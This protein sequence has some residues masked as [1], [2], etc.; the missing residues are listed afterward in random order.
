M[1]VYRNTP[2]NCF[3][4]RNEKNQMMV[5]KHKRFQN[6]AGNCIFPYYD[7]KCPNSTTVNHT[8]DNGDIIIF[9]TKLHITKFHF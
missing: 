8:L 2:G 1:I 7:C 4:Y 5:N 3:L 6:I 9:N